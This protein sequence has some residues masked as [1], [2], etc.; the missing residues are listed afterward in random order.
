[1]KM[2]GHVKALLGIVNIKF[3]MTG[4]FSDYILEKPTSETAPVLPK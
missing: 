2:N 3:Q 4:D 1:M